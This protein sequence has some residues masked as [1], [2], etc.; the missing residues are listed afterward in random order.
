MAQSQNNTSN[1]ITLLN[2][3]DEV[4][5]YH[6]IK[7]PRNKIIKD[8][9]LSVE[10]HKCH[11]KQQKLYRKTLKHTSTDEDHFK[12]KTYR[13]KLKQILRKAKE[14]FYRNKCTEYRQN[15]SRLWKM[16][17]KMTNKTND[18]TDIIEYLKIKTRIIM[19]TNLLQKNLLSIFLELESSMLSKYHHPLKT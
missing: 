1:F 11:K 18:K 2:S 14:D 13:N 3:I 19:N 15:T 4:A 10:L 7:I 8:P 9:W 6:T 16:I 17:N 5:P 12:Y